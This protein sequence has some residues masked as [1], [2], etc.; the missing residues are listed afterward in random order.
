MRT[1]KIPVRIVVGKDEGEGD[2]EGE[3]LELVFGDHIDDHS[4]DQGGNGMIK[5]NRAYGTVLSSLLGK[6]RDTVCEDQL[7]EIGFALFSRLWTHSLDKAYLAVNPKDIC[8]HER[9]AM[10]MECHSANS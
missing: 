7:G 10:N 2:S 8:L 1:F 6:E 4:I 5:A 9:G 3:H